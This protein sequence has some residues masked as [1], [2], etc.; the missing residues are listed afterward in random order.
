MN[1]ELLKQLIEQSCSD[2]AIVKYS[3]KPEWLIIRSVKEKRTFS[4][5]RLCKDDITVNIDT[6][7]GYQ[8]ENFI[9]ARNGVQFNPTHKIN[10]IQNRTKISYGSVDLVAEILSI[11]YKRNICHLETI[12]D[13]RSVE[14]I[15]K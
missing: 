11:A 3:A 7:L 4:S 12:K 9:S 1:R 13:R 10:H 5:I 15:T 6:K 14:T 8:I 2:F